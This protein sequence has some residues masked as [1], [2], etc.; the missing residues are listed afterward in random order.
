MEKEFHAGALD[1]EDGDTHSHSENWEA[2][3]FRE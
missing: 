3:M 1:I 2:S